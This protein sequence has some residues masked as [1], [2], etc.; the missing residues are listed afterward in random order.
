MRQYRKY[1]FLNLF[2]RKEGEFIVVIMKRF[3]F[4][5]S[6]KKKKKIHDPCSIF[7]IRFFMTAKQ[8]HDSYFLD[9]A[10]NP[11]STSGAIE[12]SSVTSLPDFVSDIHSL[13]MIDE[14][15]SE[16][17]KI[18]ISPSNCSTEQADARDVS[19]ESLLEPCSEDNKDSH[20]A[21]EFYDSC[22]DPSGRNQSLEDQ[23]HST[24]TDFE[25]GS[26]PI[27][28]FEPT[29]PQLEP[30]LQEYQG[31]VGSA[32]TDSIS[33]SQEIPSS[34]LYHPFGVM[35]DFFRSQSTWSSCQVPADLFPL[36]Q[37]CFCWSSEDVEWLNSQILFLD[38]E[39]FASMYAMFPSSVFPSVIHRW[40]FYELV[41][42]F[43][44]LSDP[45]HDHPSFSDPIISCLGC[46]FM[47]FVV[48]FCMSLLFLV[49]T[50][51][52]M[53]SHLHHVRVCVCL[54]LRGRKRSEMLDFY[55]I[56]KLYSVFINATRFSLRS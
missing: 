52:C 54:C 33:V 13:E 1:I 34:S 50:V 40:Q 53:V 14:I 26:D 55:S 27:H 31:V 25:L 9:S 48:V 23:S 29:S 18:N 7:D 20:I 46:F 44:N 16:G 30:F 3:L 43:M 28:T 38:C 19:V 17:E 41:R 32:T 11:I 45:N 37:H 47:I 12:D 6:Q 49:C 4:F 24:I 51:S 42:R 2:R 36:L 10:V 15:L 5:T 35:E 56:W 39:T 21:F 22:F 8:L